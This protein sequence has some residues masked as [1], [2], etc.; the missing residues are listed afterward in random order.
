MEKKHVT[1]STPKRE[2]FVIEVYPK[3]IVKR[4]RFFRTK[5]ETK[6]FFRIKSVRY[7]EIVAQGTTNGYDYFE[8]CWDTANN[9][10]LFLYY[11]QISKLEEND[12]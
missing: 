5:K 3:K 4:R 10:R 2:Q 1:N 12:N 11:S 7:N 9:L 8:D 6:W